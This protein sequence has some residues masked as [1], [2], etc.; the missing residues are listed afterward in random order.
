MLFLQRSREKH[1]SNRVK[2]ESNLF[3]WITKISSMTMQPCNTVPVTARH[4]IFYETC[5][6]VSAL[7]TVLWESLC[8]SHAVWWTMT[9]NMSICRS[10]FMSDLHLLI[11][12]YFLNQ[13]SWNTIN[14]L[15][16]HLDMW[17]GSVWYE[18]YFCTNLL[19]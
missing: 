5:C 9:L 2:G 14:P 12:C 6:A 7:V 17:A 16:W 4:F 11:C 13:N 3:K 10:S 19:I 18:Q 1:S 15:R 8:T